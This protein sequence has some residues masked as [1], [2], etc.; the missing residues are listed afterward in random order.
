MASD[1]HYGHEATLF[2]RTKIE[3]DRI[4]SIL[5]FSVWIR[6]AKAE[7]DTLNQNGYLRIGEG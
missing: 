5:F 4:T 2:S 3:E 6:D 1:I 7:L